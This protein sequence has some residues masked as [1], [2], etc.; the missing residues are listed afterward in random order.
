MKFVSIERKEN[1]EKVIVNTSQICS[2]Y[3]QGDTV[4]LSMSDSEILSTKFSDVEHAVDYL[5]RAAYVA[6]THSYGEFN[7]KRH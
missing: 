7:I 5:N 2:I 1:T 3:K 4:V 6:E